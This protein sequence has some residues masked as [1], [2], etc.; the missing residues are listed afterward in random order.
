[1]LAHYETTPL[2]SFKQSLEKT[3]PEVDVRF[4]PGVQI[5]R[6]IPLVD[7]DVVVDPRTGSSGFSMEFWKNMSHS[8]TPILTEHRPS[9][10]LICYDGL[11]PELTT[12][13]RYSYRGQAVLTPKTTGLH[14]FSLS[15]CGPAKLILDGNVLIDIE[16]RWDSPKSTLFMSYASPEERV[17]I[18]MEAGR[19]YTVTVE[20]ISR[21]PEPLNFSYFGEM[22]REEVMDGARLGFMEETTGDLV[23]EAVDLAKASDVVIMVVGRD[24]D[25]ETETSDI[26]SLGLPGDTNALIEKVLEVNS[27]VI[28]AIQAGGPV[29]M[30]W[31]DQASTIVHVSRQALLPSNARIAH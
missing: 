11:P 6:Y 20:A 29:A 22:R 27:N 13:E 25:W 14:S 31:I 12:G 21:E 19:Q 10:L 17:R 2:T 9:S 30:P 1:L 26:D 4:A 5:H 18:F 28:I 15:T 3:F 16:R 7:P 23:Q 24:R 8:G